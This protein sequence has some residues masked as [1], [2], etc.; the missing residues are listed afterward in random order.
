MSELPS[1]KILLQQ[2]WRCTSRNGQL[3][4]EFGKQKDFYNRGGLGYFHKGVGLE[5]Q[6]GL[7]EN[8]NSKHEIVLATDNLVLTLS[9]PQVYFPVSRRVPT[10]W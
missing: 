5:C 8:G 10:T 6:A 2:V 4:K 7:K 3:L 9:C 1:S